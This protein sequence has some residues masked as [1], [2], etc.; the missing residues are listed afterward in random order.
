MEETAFINSTNKLGLL[1]FYF[2]FSVLV[3]SSVNRPDFYSDPTILIISSTS[4]F[5][6]NK[7]NPFPGLT[8]PA[9]LIFLSNFCNTD[10]VALVANLG[11][12]L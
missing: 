12:N 10:D 1:F 7:V 3:A 8:A 5:E 2:I 9:P 11:K 4:S 6:M